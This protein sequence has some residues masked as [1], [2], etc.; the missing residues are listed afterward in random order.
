MG[1]VVSRWLVFFVAPLLPLILVIVVS[2]V[3]LI[4]G[5][6]LFNF[7]GLDVIGGL[8]FAVAIGCGAV[9]ALLLVVHAA[10]I[11]LLYPAISVE[12][13]D[14]YDAASRAPRWLSGS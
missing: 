13:S 10:G 3:P 5:L 2:L 1:F 11:H 9:M 12:G 7:P 4:G 6:V 8:L 14:S